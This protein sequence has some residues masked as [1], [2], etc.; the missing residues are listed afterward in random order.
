[1]EGAIRLADSAGHR[2]WPQATAILAPPGALTA[3]REILTPRGK[4][5]PRM[6][7][8]GKGYMTPALAGSG[9][10]VIVSAAT[11]VRPSAVPTRSLTT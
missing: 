5:L 7:M 11:L 1:L 8:T 9:D 6:L 10:M 2:P 4:S 3:K